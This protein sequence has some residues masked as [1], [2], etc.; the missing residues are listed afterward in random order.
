M[1]RTAPVIDVA[2]IGFG[3]EHGDPHAPRRRSA[4]GAT[5]DAGPVGAV[6]DDVDTVQATLD[7]RGSGVDPP[8]RGSRGPLGPPPTAGAPDRGATSAWTWRSRA[9]SRRASVSSESFR[10]PTAK[11]L[12]PLSDQGLWLA[13]ITAPGI[14]RSAHTQATAGVGASPI[15]SGRRRPRR[16]PSVNA[17]S[18]QRSRSRRV[19][20]PTTNPSDP[21]MRPRRR[22]HRGHAP[23]RRRAR[24]P[25]L[26]RHRCR[27][28]GSRGPMPCG[29]GQRFEYCGA[30]RAFLRPYFLDS[31]LRSSRVRNPA[32]L[33]SGRISGIDVDQGT[34]DGVAQR[35]GLA[36][37]AAAVDAAVD[38]VGLGQSR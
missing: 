18:I 15:T 29:A 20:R 33:S 10:P 19:S 1:G 9:A 35:T 36:G 5:L 37:D 6:D 4:A 26:A 8:A 22:P 32:F 27:S 28:G 12:I 38:V 2:T 13:E 30:L 16:D 34:S 14:R 23:D 11:N 7:G 3:V 24:R 31:F 25:D 21:P 17:D